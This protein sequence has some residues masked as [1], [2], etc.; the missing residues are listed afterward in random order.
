M[1]DIAWAFRTFG[2]KTGVTFAWQSVIL[3]VRRFISGKH[4]K[5]TM[6]HYGVQ[7]VAKKTVISYDD[8]LN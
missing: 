1:K 3:F 7:D 6:D 8:S 5:L 2:F 4:K